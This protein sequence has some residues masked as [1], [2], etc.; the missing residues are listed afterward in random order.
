MNVVNYTSNHNILGRSSLLAGARAISDKNDWAHTSN[1]CL[2]WRTVDVSLP[3]GGREP[4]PVFDVDNSNGIC[5]A[6]KRLTREGRMLRYD[7]DGPTGYEGPHKSLRSIPHPELS[8]TK[9]SAAR[10]TNPWPLVGKYVVNS[11]EKPQCGALTMLD[12]S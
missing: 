10:W 3:T 2:A 9:Q 4:P 6:K 12:N 11:T 8:T 1:L 5:F 7:R